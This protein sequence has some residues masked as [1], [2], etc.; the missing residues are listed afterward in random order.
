M[1]GFI[2]GQL[3]WRRVCAFLLTLFLGGCQ[4]QTAE[5]PVLAEGH[6]FI[7]V[8]A[9]SVTQPGFTVRAGQRYA[10]RSEMLW[11]GEG[12]EGPYRRALTR[13]NIDREI[14]RQLAELGLVRVGTA[15]A[16]LVL[17]AAV[18]IGE[19]TDGAATQELARLYPSLGNVSLTLEKG[20]LLLALGR[21]GS[22]VV[23]WRGAIQT[24]ISDN[25]EPS[26][27][28]ERLQIIVHSLLNSLPLATPAP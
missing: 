22:P 28:Q 17:V 21:A 10:W 4:T 2:A 27:R 13:L 18:R 23:M 1:T 24:F 15:E 9:V 7:P 14:D 20:T 12:A 25:I 8:S 5:K 11:I 19:S 6:E 3:G 26:Q 16:D